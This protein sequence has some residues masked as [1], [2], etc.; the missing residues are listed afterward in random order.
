MFCSVYF[1]LFSTWEVTLGCYPG[2]GEISRSEW[3]AA[4]SAAAAAKAQ[5]QAAP[6]SRRQQLQSLFEEMDLGNSGFIDA[7]EVSKLAQTRRE[8]YQKQG[9]RTWTE[10]MNDRLLKKIDTD[11]DGRIDKQEFVEHYKGLFETTDEQHFA[12]W[13]HEFREVI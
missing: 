1:H 2:D 11:G 9:D 5:R 6:L 12:T 8:L 7:D 10:T 4:V 13:F 3:N